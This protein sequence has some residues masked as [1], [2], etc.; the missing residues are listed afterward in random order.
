MSR[1]AAWKKVGFREILEDIPENHV[2]EFAMI[3]ISM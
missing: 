1:C 3:T 2:F